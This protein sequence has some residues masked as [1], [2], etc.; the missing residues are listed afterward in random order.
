MCVRVC[1]SVCICNLRR[2]LC[3]DRRYFKTIFHNFIDIEYI[4]VYTITLRQQYKPAPTHNTPPLSLV[5]V[6][7]VVSASAEDHA[8]SPG[9]EPRCEGWHLRHAG[10][11]SKEQ[12]HRTCFNINNVVVIH[13]RKNALMINITNMVCTGARHV[14][15]R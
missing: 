11:A 2:G 4:V 9:A 7:G 3:R 12:K 15:V 8:T 14:V 10:S 5:S 13:R 6:L 1:V